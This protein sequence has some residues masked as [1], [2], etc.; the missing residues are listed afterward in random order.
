LTAVSA[1]V[2]IENSTPQY[3]RYALYEGQSQIPASVLY[4][5]DHNLYSSGK[6]Y[7]S[8]VVILHPALPSRNLRIFDIALQKVW[9]THSTVG[10]NE[11][12]F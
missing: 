2:P 12:T 4:D 3:Y 7:L 8:Q 5:V 9:V 10:A 6:I 11:N 1:N